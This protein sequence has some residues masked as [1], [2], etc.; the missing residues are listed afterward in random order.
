[1]KVCIS[2]EQVNLCLKK[3]VHEVLPC[4]PA[5]ILT[6]SF[7]ILKILLLLEE[8]PPKKITTYFMIE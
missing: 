1:M 2:L 4:A 6:T 7:C 3:L 8:L 5:I